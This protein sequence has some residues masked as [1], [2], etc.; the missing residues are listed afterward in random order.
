[1]R[2]N[3]PEIDYRFL[4][5]I[6]VERETQRDIQSF[7]LSLFEGCE[8]VV[9]LGCGDGD[10]VELLAE[11]GIEAIG[12]D[13][14]ERCCQEA[15]AR[16]L[17]IVCQ[18]VFEYLQSLPE[19]GLDGIFAGHLVEHFH[20]EDVISLLRLSH[21]A[22]RE[23]GIVV[24]TTPN[25]RGLFSHLDMF[26]LHF[27]HVNFYHPRLLCF[28]L[29]YTGYSEAQM[30]ENPKTSFPLWGHLKGQ[31]QKEPSLIPTVKYDPLLPLPPH[32]LRR[33]IWRGKMFLV[34]LIVQP[35]LDTIVSEINDSLGILDRVLLDLD[36]PFECYAW[37]RKLVTREV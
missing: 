22:L 24:L 9:D 37:A 23:G 4:R 35:Y 36:R 2:D 31:N 25:V 27:G 34:R 33:L 30:G 13:R 20:Y 5:Y 18:D 3:L 7:Y 11:N 14:D 28:L 1:M 26:Y 17:E 10:F 6:G 19:G 12:V 16:G 21:S 29:E 15:R 32:F 8:R